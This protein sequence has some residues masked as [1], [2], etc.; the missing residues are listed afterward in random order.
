MWLGGAGFRGGLLLGATESVEIS[1]GVY[2]LSEGSSPRFNLFE[3]TE[4]N[5]AA[6]FG[7]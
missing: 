6:G 7:F 5:F 4:I 2:R 3:S 1:F